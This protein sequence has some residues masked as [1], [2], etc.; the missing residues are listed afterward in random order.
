MGKATF[1]KKNKTALRPSGDLFDAFGAKLFPVTICKPPISSYCHALIT[2]SNHMSSRH[3]Q[4]SSFT[5]QQLISAHH[6]IITISPA[7]FITPV[8]YRY[9]SK[10]IAGGVYYLHEGRSAVLFF[11]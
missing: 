7:F 4:F 6:C 10:E 3:N 11:L 9:K 8:A 1:Y 2:Q 5:T